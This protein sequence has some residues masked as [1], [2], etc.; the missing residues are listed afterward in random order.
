MQSRRW[1]LGLVLPLRIAAAPIQGEKAAAVVDDL[2][3]DSDGAEEYGLAWSEAE[4]LEWAKR[5]GAR[6]GRVAWHFITELAGR[7][8]QSL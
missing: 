6:S 2:L 8:G 1:A 3:G 7:A 4:A 5:R